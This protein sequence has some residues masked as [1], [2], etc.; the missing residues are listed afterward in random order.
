[1]GAAEV[2]G[3]RTIEGGSVNHRPNIIRIQPK[4]VSPD[5]ISVVME[6]IPSV[7]HLLKLRQ[8]SKLFDTAAFRISLIKLHQARSVQ[9]FFY[10]EVEKYD[11]D[12][13]MENLEMHMA[14]LQYRREKLLNKLNVT[15]SVCEFY[16]FGQPPDYI[17]YIGEALGE[18]ASFIP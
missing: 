8:V 13:V 14:T 10:H 3:G 18:A 2:K 6:Y 1:M 5:V 12:H 15:Q 7:K 4:N 17:F 9:S 16:T 11:P